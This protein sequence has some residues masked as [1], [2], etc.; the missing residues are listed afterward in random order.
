MADEVAGNEFQ[1]CSN[2]SY[3]GRLRGFIAYNNSFLDN[4]LNRHGSQVEYTYGNA[5]CDNNSTGNFWSNYESRYPNATNDGIIWDTPYEIWPDDFEDRYPL[6]KYTDRIAHLVRLIHNATTY[7]DTSTTFSA[8]AIDNKGISAYSWS[9]DNGKTWTSGSSVTTHTWTVP[10]D[11]AIMV[12]VWDAANL[13]GETTSRIRVLD[14]SQ[15]VS[16][17][18]DD[19]TI[20]P[21]TVLKL[22]ASLSTDD[23][24]IVSYEWT[25]DY[26]GAPMSLSGVE[27]N[28]IID[29]EDVFNITLTVRDEAGNSA[30]DVIKVTVE[31]K[32]PP[33]AVIGEDHIIDQ[34]TTLLLSGLNST[35]NWRID[36]WNW[37]VTS[38]DLATAFY[39][40]SEISHIFHQAGVHT[41][42][43]RVTDAAGLWNTT[44]I[45][46]TVLDTTDPVAVLGNDNT[47]DQ[48]DTLRLD[49][50]ASSDNVGVVNWTWT[51]TG[52]GM[53]AVLHGPLQDHVFPDAGAFNVTL[54]VTDDAG[55]HASATFT[56]T[57]RDITAPLADAGADITVDE[58]G[59]VTFDGG[60]SSDNVGVS[61]YTWTFLYDGEAV[62]QTRLVPLYIFVFDVPGEYTVT[63]KVVDDEG[64]EDTDQLVVTVRDITPPVAVAGNDRVVDQ[65]TLV[66]FN[67]SA[68]SDNVAVVELKWYFEYEGEL[69]ILNG[70]DPQFTFHLAG[71]YVVTLQVW[72]AAAHS[73]TDTL[74]VTVMDIDPPIVV[75]GDDILADLEGTVQFDGSASSD[76]VGIFRYFWT[77]T[78]DDRDI[79]WEEVSMSW[80]FDLPGEYV[81]TLSVEDTSGNVGTDTLTVTVED[82]EPPVADAGE[83]I[84]VDQHATVTFDGSGSSDNVG[85]ESLR[86]TFEHEDEPKVLRGPSPEFTFHAAGVYQVILEVLDVTG[87][88]AED[89]VTVT[90]LDTEPPKAVAGEDMI[91]LTGDAATFDAS[92]STD[93]LAIVSWTWTFIE[94]DVER[95][96]EGRT[97]SFT[98]NTVGE[99]MVTLTV[100]DDC[101]NSDTDTLVVIVKSEPN[102]EPPD[103]GGYSLAIMGGAAAAIAVAAVL[104]VLYTRRKKEVD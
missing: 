52:P 93:N 102:D 81:V 71:E 95:T 28:F 32:V 73:V 84:V 68:S 92:N 72:D 49:G 42:T 51:I 94:T 24:G 9:F 2:P 33:V 56:V 70:T 37:T 26:D 3:N 14:I 35:D 34:H 77:F 15:P 87:N 103:D 18:G 11:Y 48:Y 96:F 101:G 75:A 25:F 44:V 97:S 89:T 38:P 91:S 65:P 60:G 27:A 23:L 13:M 80:T 36:L 69:R 47:V 58:G 39:N 54:T 43:L 12:R 83:D 66:T 31:D 86:W 4:A 99:Y 67:G 19:I 59:T 16:V 74:S 21:G 90:V 6:V 64:N 7:P 50:T 79:M 55:N 10:G 53:D 5:Q 85:L 61:W 29:M 30:Q 1:N 82:P 20:E 104:A 62:V 17:A 57:V 98:F 46:V 63:L 76:N 41:V 45:K 22:N 8:W 40:T 88:R 78:Y 100:A